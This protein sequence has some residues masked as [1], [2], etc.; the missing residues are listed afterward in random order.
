M[1]IDE[2]AFQDIRINLLFD[3]CFSNLLFN[4]FIDEYVSQRRKLQNSEESLQ[5]FLVSRD[6]TLERDE[7]EIGKGFEDNGVDVEDVAIVEIK[8]INFTVFDVDT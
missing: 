5:L 6:M 4:F 7:P 8:L 2:D 3:Y 1:L